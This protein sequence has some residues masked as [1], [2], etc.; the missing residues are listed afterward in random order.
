MKKFVLILF[1]L[2]LMIPARAQIVRTEQLSEVTVYATNYKYLNSVGNAEPA[3]IPV[4]M[5]ERKVAAFNLMDSDF[6]N[7]EYDYYQISFYIPE[8]KILAAYDAN[9]KI[10]RTVERF[11]QVALPVSVRDAV[12]KRF[13]GW[14][15]SKD[16]YAVTY[17]EEK[18]TQKRYKLVLI[19]G[20]KKLRVKL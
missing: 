20:D 12:A 18:G 9:G 3:A 11:E 10:I 19:N 13:P 6:Y 16:V 14:T 8:G 17:H 15:V 2:G 5:L 4:S 7:D 1:S